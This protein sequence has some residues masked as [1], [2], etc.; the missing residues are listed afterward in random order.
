VFDLGL[1]QLTRELIKRYKVAAEPKLPYSML[2]EVELYPQWMP[3]LCASLPATW[4]EA[5][6]AVV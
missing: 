5:V 3:V 4:H 6:L 1:L 2:S